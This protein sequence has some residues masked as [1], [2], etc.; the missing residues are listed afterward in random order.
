MRDVAEQCPVSRGDQVVAFVDGER[1]PQGGPVDHRNHDGC[2]GPGQSS[3]TLLAV[4][5]RPGRSD[6][7]VVA[8]Y[9]LAGYCA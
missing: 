1:G 2:V 9:C 8:G 6:R 7:S 4:T 5:G 3:V